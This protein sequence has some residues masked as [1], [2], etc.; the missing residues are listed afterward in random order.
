MIFLLDQDKNFFT[1]SCMLDLIYEHLVIDWQLETGKKQENQYVAELLIGQT[2][3][4]KKME[5][6]II[7]FWEIKR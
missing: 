4:G 5:F 1:T 2:S 7:S 6:N 3:K